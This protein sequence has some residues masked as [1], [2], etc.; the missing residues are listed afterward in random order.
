MTTL[1]LVL[2]FLHL[3][4]G[5]PRYASKG[6]SGTVC[7][8]SQPCK[9]DEAVTQSGVDAR[10]I[11][12]LPGEYTLADVGLQTTLRLTK[13]FR[14]F[15]YNTGGTSF[16]EQPVFDLDTLTSPN[17]L[18]DVS[19]SGT[20]T[21]TLDGLVFQ[22]QNSSNN[23]VLSVDP[24]N[25]C[26]VVVR[27]SVFRQ[28]AARLVWIDGQTQ[29]QQ[30]TFSECSFENNDGSSGGL[31]QMLDAALVTVDATVFRD[32]RDSSSFTHDGGCIS[33]KTQPG[34]PA[35]VLNVTGSS[36]VN[37]RR[38]GGASACITVWPNLP[39]QT[40]LNIRSTEFLGNVASGNGAA[41]FLE[42]I[43]NME[44]TG[45]VFERNTGTGNEGGA[46]RV[47]G[48]NNA[49]LF[50]TCTFRGN[51]GMQGGAIGLG[52]TM[53]WSQQVFPFLL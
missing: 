39:G 24:M 30:V 34:A 43:H 22:N 32:N 15:A 17:S 50:D 38:P 25:T 52:Q 18:F 3:V 47:G 4:V 29:T 11:A 51:S 36:F 49:C 2:A 13:G 53:S 44:V 31:I 8:Q 9:L 16:A 20:A 10:D 14:I 46:V 12:V 45:C 5:Q 27:R 6:G 33:V 37:N 1:V 48:C 40:T 42:G 7:L 41:V 19:C 26:A 35:V 23:A 28:S 21:V